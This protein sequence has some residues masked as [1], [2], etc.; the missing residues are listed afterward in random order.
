MS[1]EENSN[2]A[3]FESEAMELSNKYPDLTIS[4][5]GTAILVEVPESPDNRSFRFED[6]SM[7]R[8]LLLNLD[9][10][11]SVRV[12][13]NKACIMVEDRFF[14]LLGFPS[15]RIP[16]HLHRDTP[17]DFFYMEEP[18]KVR[19]VM[20]PPG[21]LGNLLPFLR[22]DTLARQDDVIED[23][24]K[25][26]AAK[27][28]L[29][30]YNP[31]SGEESIYER[32]FPSSDTIG[33][34][35]YSLMV[36]H[37][38]RGGSRTVSPKIS[39]RTGELHI[40]RILKQTD[41]LFNKAPIMSDSLAQI[42]IEAP[43]QSNHAVLVDKWSKLT[44]SIFFNYYYS[45]GSLPFILGLEDKQESE[46]RTEEAPTDLSSALNEISFRQVEPTLMQYLLVAERTN[47]PTF[48]YLSFYH[49]L[50]FYFD[51]VVNPRVADEIR[52]IVL[53]P[54][55]LSRREMYT[56]RIVKIAQG[57]PRTDKT[58]NLEAL[59]L[60]LV[61]ERFLSRDFFDN[62]PEGMKERLSATA[63]FNGRPSLNPVV[64]AD[65]QGPESDHS[66]KRKKQAKDL[67]REFDR[68]ALFKSLAQRIYDLRCSIVHSN[69]DFKGRQ[70]PL[71]L[72]QSNLDAVERESAVLRLIAC[73]V[74]SKALDLQII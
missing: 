61:L 12:L 40:R 46:T 11:K 73:E 55:F 32:L 20:N 44:D 10:F 58:L 50:E 45:T 21:N 2:G 68:Q 41:A 56:S 34:G 27:H 1:H 37:L 26:L 28:E 43:S 9:G 18:F 19:I 8:F 65:M 17:F 35:L 25:E 39:F 36:G 51:K 5:D 53:K 66:K 6:A 3:I 60:I 72:C 4:T 22:E 16:F 70:K 24:K 7:L 54:D 74:I 59:K 15:S 31:R 30:R 62:L 71:D 33:L 42:I 38:D 47:L 69:P 49:I 13:G 63:D 48:R 52:N 57:T 14:G 23:I 29:P 67:V 64:F